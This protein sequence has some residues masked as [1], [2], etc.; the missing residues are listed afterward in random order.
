MPLVL[1]TRTPRNIDLL[2]TNGSPYGKVL[3]DLGY[4]MTLRGQTTTAAHLYDSL[5]ASINVVYD[6]VV[7]W[8]GRIN[9]RSHPTEH[10]L[11]DNPFKVID[12]PW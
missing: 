9:R 4:S 12:G 11:F 7:N 2:P 1:S 3:K 10:H 8:K 5:I 6:D